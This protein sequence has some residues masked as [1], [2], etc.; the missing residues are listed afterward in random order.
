VAGAT[1]PIVVDVLNALCGFP[2]VKYCKFS[3]AFF[4][5]VPFDMAELAETLKSLFLAAECKDVRVHEEAGGECLQVSA[6]I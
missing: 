4:A 6:Y 1:M 3:L 2:C 5:Y